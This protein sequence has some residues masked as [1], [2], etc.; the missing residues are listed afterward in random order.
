MSDEVAPAGA[1]VLPEVDDVLADALTAQGEAGV[2]ALGLLRDAHRVLAGAG[3]V[4]PAEVAAACVRSAADA[5][6]GLPGAPVTVGLKPAAE[7][8]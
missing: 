6:L 5:L 2:R 3:F 7:G 8:L 4:R 1:S